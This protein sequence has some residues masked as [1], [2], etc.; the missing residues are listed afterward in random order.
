MHYRLIKIVVNNKHAK[1]LVL[2]KSNVIAPITSKIP[3]II[4]YPLVKL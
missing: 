2:L 1:I 3:M 4:G